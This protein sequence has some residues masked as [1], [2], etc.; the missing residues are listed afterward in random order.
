MNIHLVNSD[1]RALICWYCENEKKSKRDG[2]IR[3]YTLGQN[4]RHKTWQN[5]YQNIL[6]P[7]SKRKRRNKEERDGG[8]GEK[9]ADRVGKQNEKRKGTKN[10]RNKEKQRLG[11][12]KEGEL[13]PGF[14][15]R[16]RRRRSVK[17]RRKEGRRGRGEGRGEGSGS[18]QDG[19]TRWGCCRRRREKV[20]NADTRVHGG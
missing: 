3:H 13:S 1:N 16:S 8:R 15:S 14:L 9:W 18:A 4:N 7:R 10:R 12:R 20:E 19:A 17:E 5:N 2:N 6:D 11:M